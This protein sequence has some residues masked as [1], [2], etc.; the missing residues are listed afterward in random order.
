M[1]GGEK[2]E[3]L[4]KTGRDFTAQPGSPNPKTSLSDVKF[5]AARNECSVIHGACG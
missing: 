5:L 3:G 2:A 1:A 4:I